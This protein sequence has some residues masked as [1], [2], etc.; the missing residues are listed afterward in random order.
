MKKFRIKPLLIELRP[1]KMIKGEIGLFAVRNIEQGAITAHANKMGENFVPWVK[2]NKIDKITQ[3]KVQEFCLQTEDGFFAPNDLNY[4][5]VPWYMN[6]SCSYNIGFDNK[7][8]FIAIRNIKNGEEL[9]FD[10]GLAVSNPGFRLVCKCKSKNCRKVI[11][12]N[13]WLNEN[14]VEKNKNYILR[15][16]LTMRRNN[17]RSTSKK[18]NNWL[19]VIKTTNPQN[20][21]L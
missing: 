1:S 13:D 12:G 10:Y 16:L 4:L 3:K 15:E 20:N 8:N 5:S 18:M 6:H 11:P 2:Y 14:F 7:G 19:C 9:V 17:N 21:I